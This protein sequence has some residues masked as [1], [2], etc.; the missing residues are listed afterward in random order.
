MGQKAIHECECED[1][2]GAAQ[3][4]VKSQHELINLLMSRLDEQ[5]RCWYA[6]VESERIGY[7]GD[8]QVTRITGLDVETI[9]RGRRE[10]A[11]KLAHR[12]VGR[13]RVAGG[14]RPRVEKKA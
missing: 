1:C 14:G 10:L 6:A 13:V 11:D 12:P 2:Q 4:D 5:Q 8:T 7:G 3:T 9:R